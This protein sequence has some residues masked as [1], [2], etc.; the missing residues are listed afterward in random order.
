M[1]DGPEDSE[2]STSMGLERMAAFSDGVFAIAITLLVLPL[3]DARIREHH[4]ADDLR[5]LGPEIFTFALTFAVIGRFW[6]AH[7]R[8]LRGFVAADQAM[9]YLNLVFLFCIVF[10]PFP[11]SVLGQG[12]GTAPV[13]LYAANIMA[14]GLASATLV[15]YASRRHR[16]VAVADSRMRLR[17]AV[18]GG[19]ATMLGFLPS[20]PLAFVSPTWAKLSWLLLLPSGR[21]A[22]RL[23]ERARRRTP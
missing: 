13:V 15:G 2:A 9:L 20:I 17:E 11:T 21:L 8:Q 12:H 7:H 6:V 18:A 3:T 4:V 5:H 16:L 1:V 10:L 14:A 22:D 23:V 19:L